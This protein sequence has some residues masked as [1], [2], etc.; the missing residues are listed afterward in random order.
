MIRH[1]ISADVTPR[2][3]RG[4]WGRRL[5]AEAE[6]WLLQQGIHTLR[7]RV[8]A[9]NASAISFYR[10]CGYRIGPSIDVL[11]PGSTI[12]VHSIEKRL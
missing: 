7:A 3:R 12:P 8:A 10:A 9:P 1:L 4:G 5:L 11:R 6:S 2:C